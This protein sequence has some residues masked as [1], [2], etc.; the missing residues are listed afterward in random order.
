MAEIQCGSRL[1]ARGPRAVAWRCPL[2]LIPE[3]GADY[4]GENGTSMAAPHVAAAAALLWSLR[5]TL[6]QQQ[7]EA[8]LT[9]DGAPAGAAA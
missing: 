6:T 5:P 4:C 2:G 1:S 9:G 7:V 8:A 3:N